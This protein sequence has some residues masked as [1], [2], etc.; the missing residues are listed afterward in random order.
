MQ[1]TP[2]TLLEETSDLFDVLIPVVQRS[3]EA[4]QHNPNLLA[5]HLIQ[6]EIKH[7]EGLLQRL[8]EIKKRLH[9]HLNLSNQLAEKSSAITENSDHGL[10][11]QGKPLSGPQTF[12][13]KSK[14]ISLTAQQVEELK[15]IYNSDKAR[16]PKAGP[17]GAVK[18]ILVAQR[19][20]P[21]FHANNAWNAVARIVGHLTPLQKKKLRESSK[22]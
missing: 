2:E 22:I 15:S 12:T 13:V 10:K 18:R 6:Q 11:I 17:T 8:E 7:Q 20:I 1:E 5:Q 4:L 9:G 21:E 19:I 14:S 16:N 3:I